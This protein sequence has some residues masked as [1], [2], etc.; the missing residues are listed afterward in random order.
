M[1]GIYRYLD[2]WHDEY[3]R[4]VLTCRYARG[5]WIARGSVRRLDTDESVGGAQRMEKTQDSA[6]SLVAQD[7]DNCMDSFPRPPPEWGRVALRMLLVDHEN[8]NDTLTSSLVKLEQLG[9]AGQLTPADL[10]EFHHKNC[11]HVIE[12]SLHFSQ[13]LQSLS[14]QD[15]IDLMTSPEDVYKAP[16]DPW[17][18]ADM[19]GRS[20]MFRFILNPSAEVTRAHHKHE[21]RATNRPDAHLIAADGAT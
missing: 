11:E 6:V 9:R 13:R 15:R 5:V 16:L 21:N 7:L 10:R 3:Y 18:L 8:F 17:K 19:S 4:V 20:D 1:A 2:E 12:S 14:E